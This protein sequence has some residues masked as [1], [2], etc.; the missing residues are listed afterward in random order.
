MGGLV[1]CFHGGWEG[2]DSWDV[3]FVSVGYEG[4]D[5][6]EVCLGCFFYYR[7]LNFVGMRK[8]VHYL[9]FGL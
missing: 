3:F 1:V 7:W 5:N 2:V 4:L 9:V 6:G 8:I